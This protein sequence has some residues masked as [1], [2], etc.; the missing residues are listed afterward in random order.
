MILY[1]LSFTL[2]LVLSLCLTP[3]VRAA[4]R[5]AGLLDVPDGKRKLHP[6]SVP[7]L[8]G[9]AVF[10]S[11][12]ACLLLVV[13]QL[14][15]PAAYRGSGWSRR[16]APSLLILALGIADDKW[17]VSPWVKIGVQI[18]AGLIVYYQLGIRINTLTSLFIG[19]GP[20]LGVLSLAATLF[21]IVLS[22]MRST[23]STA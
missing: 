19:T 2:A 22:R 12:Y 21:W 3:P 6:T 8:G 16:F 15:S 1:G 9:V 7:L 10:V 17:S 4:A 20:M 13:T 23:S 14:H 18:V 5:W 11:F